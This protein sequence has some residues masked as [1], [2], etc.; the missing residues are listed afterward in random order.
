[1]TKIRFNNVFCMLFF[2]DTL[3]TILTIKGSKSKSKQNEPIL[4]L[5]K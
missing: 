2:L 4:G 1:M 3:K 5:Y